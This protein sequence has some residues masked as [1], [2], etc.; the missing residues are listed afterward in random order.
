MTSPRHNKEDGGYLVTKEES[1][2]IQK[3]AVRFWDRFIETY[4]SMFGKLPDDLF[5]EIKEA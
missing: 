3:A 4:I 1:I 5:K 2:E